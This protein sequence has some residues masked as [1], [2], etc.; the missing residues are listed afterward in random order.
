MKAI[1]IQKQLET[2][3]KETKNRLEQLKSETTKAQCKNQSYE[4]TQ[5]QLRV[6]EVEKEQLY[7]IL[8]SLR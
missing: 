7:K 2:L 1:T 3:K 6:I 4:D 8:E 5:K